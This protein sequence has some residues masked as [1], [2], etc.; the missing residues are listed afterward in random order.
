MTALP[1]AERHGADDVLEIYGRAAGR[2]DLVNAIA[3]LGTGRWYR[4][5]TIRT[6][7]L[8]E[9]AAVLDVGCGTGALALAAQRHCPASSLVVGVDPSEEMRTLARRAGVRDVRAGGFESL[10]FT[11]ASFDL[12]TSGYAIRYAGDL[13]ETARELRRILKPGGLLV[14]LEM[15]APTTP[16]LR[17][18][19]GRGIRGVGAPVLG[20]LCGS[21]AVTDLMRHFWDSVDGFAAPSVVVRSLRSAGLVEAEYRP[22]GGLLGEFRAAR[23]D[24]D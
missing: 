24:D 16:W 15:I 19:V 11:D 7:D 6:L 4:E 17:A 8:P 18:L 20:M 13:G 2:Y 1:H 10:P 23:P 9:D 21:R 5:R 22:L 14:L 3:S 12:V